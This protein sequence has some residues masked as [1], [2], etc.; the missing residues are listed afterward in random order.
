MDKPVYS[1]C[2]REVKPARPVA[3]RTSGRLAGD[4]QAQALAFADALPVPSTPHGHATVAMTCHTPWR[5]PARSPRRSPGRASP[6]APPALSRRTAA[7]GML[8]VRDDDRPAPSRA[9]RA[10][11]PERTKR[12][13][14]TDLVPARTMAPA[15]QPA[16]SAP[17][18]AAAR[19]ASPTPPSMS[20]S[21]RWPGFRPTGRRVR[22]ATAAI[23]AGSFASSAPRTRTARPPHQAGEVR[24]SLRGPARKTSRRPAMMRSGG[25]RPG[26]LRPWR[27][28]RPIQG[29]HRG[30][31]LAGAT[32][33][34]CFHPRRV[35]PACA[36]ARDCC[37]QRQFGPGPESVERL[38]TVSSRGYAHVHR[39]KVPVWMSAAL[40]VRRAPGE[41]K[42]GR[43]DGADPVRDAVEQPGR[44][45]CPQAPA[46]PA[47]TAAAR[48]PAVAGA[49]MPPQ[50]AWI[51]T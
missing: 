4:C 6:R 28:Q 44:R 12:G 21:S 2:F 24:L 14:P 25:W 19:S 22:F 18:R 50:P 5:R 31:E 10:S 48:S 3:L 26:S 27:Q 11:R 32:A 33:Q 39:G 46:R 35:Y 9:R 51:R 49:A 40:R 37:R 42:R 36:E 8:V 13:R 43:C 38:V 34:S 30:R 45:R 29:L 7:P 16:M 15:E 17:R 41:R 1:D 20:A 47:G 23:A